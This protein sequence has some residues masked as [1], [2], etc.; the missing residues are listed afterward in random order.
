MNYKDLY[1]LKV[2]AKEK[3]ITK[4]AEKLFV[5]QP[6]LTYKIKILEE[7]LD[8]KILLRS[9]KGV[10]FTAE[11]SYLIKYAEKV[12]YDYQKLKDHLQNFNKFEEGIIRLGVSQNLARYELPDIL[13]QFLDVYSKVQF[14]VVTSWSQSILKMIKKDEIAIAIIRGN[15]IWKHE[16]HLLNKEPICVIHKEELDINNLPNLPRINFKTDPGLQQT[17]DNWWKENFDEPP[18]VTMDIDNVETCIELVEKGL[19]YAIIPSI[20]LKKHRNIKQF[21]LHNVDGQPILR[22]TWLLYRKEDLE[23]P[24]I[25]KFIDFLKNNYTSIE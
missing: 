15:I 20:G 10:K 12:L 16:K 2:L 9:K 6:S 18:F 24:I 11:G 8:T 17:I 4:T 3:N 21:S 23:Y 22:E 25:N 14:N 7:E 5:S 13:Q 19:G 1:M